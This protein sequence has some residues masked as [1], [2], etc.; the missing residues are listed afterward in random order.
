MKKLSILLFFLSFSSLV[1]AQYCPP[2]AI[3]IT[4]SLWRT[5][6]HIVIADE[7]EDQRVELWLND[8]SGNIS[9]EF[10]GAQNGSLKVLEGRV[11]IVKGIQA[12]ELYMIDVLD[13][14]ALGSSLVMNLLQVAVPGGPQSLNQPVTVNIDEKI[15]SIMAGTPSASINIA[16]PWQLT[17]LVTL[18]N[19]SKDR[20]TV[21]FRFKLAT[22][23]GEKVVTGTWEQ[24]FP[25]PQLD[26]AMALTDWKVYNLGPRNFRDGTSNVFDYGT[27]A[28]SHTAQTLGELRQNISAQQ[29]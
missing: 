1:G 15:K 20:Q 5:G 16:P 8:D 10:I 7:R 19:S 6:N 21:N 3:C 13:G 29:K 23:Q 22:I 14:A 28:A 9:I 12:D 27:T 11:L 17:G 2:N 18:E 25:A 24:L 26:N 4:E